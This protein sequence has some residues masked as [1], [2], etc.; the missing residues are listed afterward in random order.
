MT[1]G[2][3]ITSTILYHGSAAEAVEPRFG[4]GD[5]R[6]DYGRGFYLTDSINLDLAVAKV[7]S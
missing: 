5:D 7:A 6:H 1:V 3:N 4:L 2:N